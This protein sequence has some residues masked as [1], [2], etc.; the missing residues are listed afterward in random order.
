MVK[1]SPIKNFI[2]G[3]IRLRKKAQKKLAKAIKDKKLPKA[4]EALREGAKLSK[5]FKF[6][7]KEKTP[8]QLAASVG[9]IKF[10]KFS[11]K[12][13]LEEE[14]AKQGEEFR[15]FINLC[16]KRLTDEEVNQKTVSGETALSLALD[17]YEKKIVEREGVYTIDKLD[18]L[19]KRVPEVKQEG[20]L[21]EARQIFLA[22]EHNR[23][24][25]VRYLSLRYGASYILKIT[26]EGSKKP[27]HR[28][29]EEGFV[30]ILDYIT[31][32]LGGVAQEINATDN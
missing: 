24:D 14:I 29:A 20:A 13:G 25:V 28:A 32:S 30:D 26:G 23:L 11:L 22:I 6:E 4:K 7:G 3:T 31:G 21:K 10:L 27:L 16:Y 12:S 1:K 17:Y 18:S 15:E 8:L 2:R 9:N 5:V 19:V